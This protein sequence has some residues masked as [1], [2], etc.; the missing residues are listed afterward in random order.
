[1]RP[2]PWLLLGPLDPPRH[3]PIGPRDSTHH[4]SDL[5]ARMERIAQRLQHFQHRYR[6]QLSQADQGWLH[7][8]QQQVAFYLAALSQLEDRRAVAP[9]V[10]ASLQAAVALEP[11]TGQLLQLRQIMPVTRQ[12]TGRR[13]RAA[14]RG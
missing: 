11:V 14:A 4:L 12:K 2:E 3:P 6:T 10:Q 9:E 5:I 1:M 8:A 13:G 7:Q